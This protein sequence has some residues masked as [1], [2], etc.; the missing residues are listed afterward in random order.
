MCA[1][2]GCTSVPLRR[3]CHQGSP[4]CK[5]RSRGPVSHA[6]PTGQIRRAHTASVR[7]TRNRGTQ[8]AGVCP[9]ACVCVPA[10]VTPVFS[11]RNRGM[12]FTCLPACMCVF[13]C[14]FIRLSACLRWR[15]CARVCVSSCRRVRWREGRVHGV[16]MRRLFSCV[17]ACVCVCDCRISAQVFLPHVDSSQVQTALT[18]H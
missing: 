3:T 7:S 17:C 11:T 12:L 8:Y 18:R 5:D 1:R 9:R 6:K 13:V 16:R 10:Y 15:V 4:A 2:V 14:V